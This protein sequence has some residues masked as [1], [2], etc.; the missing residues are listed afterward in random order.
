M[1]I[2]YFILALS[3]ALPLQV[4]AQREGKN[5]KKKEKTEKVK[6]KKGK[7][8]K[9]DKNNQ[10]GNTAQPSETTPGLIVDTVKQT[11]TLP[12]LSEGARPVVTGPIYTEQPVAPV[13][14][15]AQL[16]IVRDSLAEAKRRLDDAYA[17]RNDLRGQVDSLNGLINALDPIIYKECI[18]YPLSI[19]YNKQRIDESLRAVNSYRKARGDD[20]LSPDFKECIKTYLPFIEGQNPPYLQYSNELVQF[21]EKVETKLKN[22]NTGVMQSA[23]KK[24]CVERIQEL[25]YYPLYQRRNDPP[26]QSITFLDNALDSFKELLYVSKSVVDYVRILRESITPKP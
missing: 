19:R 4:C 2:K 25:K 9:G 21:L 14:N 6:E 12:A 20:H 16:S 22:S 5:E 11:T 24:D 15:P 7:K 3:L 13:A 18:L 8:N 26:Y 10:K 1:N 17:E 23:M